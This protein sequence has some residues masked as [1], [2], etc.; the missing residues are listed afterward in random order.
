MAVGVAS[1]KAQGQAITSTDINIVNENTTSPLK[2]YQII[3]DI[4]ASTIT[5]LY[6]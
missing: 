1:P 6:Q 5:I 3:D 4:N 2:K